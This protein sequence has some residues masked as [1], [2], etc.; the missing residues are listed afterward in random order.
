M[1]RGH[2]LHPER[3][4]WFASGQLDR[5][6]AAEIETHV[7]SCES[8]RAEV[9]AL[10]SM[11]QSLREDA[12]SEHVSPARLVAYHDVDARI[13]DVDRRLVA[14]H[15]DKCL[16]CS[17]DLATLQRA[18]TSTRAG[19]GRRWLGVAASV[20]IV[21]TFG[22]QTAVRRAE[23]PA[24]PAVAHVVFPPAQ[25]GPSADVPPV[26]T[27]PLEIEVWLPLH[28]QAREYRACIER[29]GESS[30]PVFD[31]V[32]TARPNKR[33]VLLPVAGGLRP[34][35]YLLTLSSLGGADSEKFPQSFDVEGQ[36]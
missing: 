1:S 36:R 27:G 9:S 30:T 11:Y 28:A 12:A 7:Q 33:S 8:C 23:S 34:G 22:W 13:S 4:P 10:R 29:S 20:L 14:E 24:S 2:A 5:A 18:E 16:T 3:L 21:M 35:H 19:Q 15:L 26:G 32:V 17:A 25:R 31:R 6:R